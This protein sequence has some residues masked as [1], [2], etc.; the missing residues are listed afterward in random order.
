[1]KHYKILGSFMW[2]NCTFAYLYCR[3][4]AV[5]GTHPLKRQLVTPSPL[6]PAFPL[7]IL[8]P[9]LFQTDG[10]C[11]PLWTP[12]IATLTHG[13]FGFYNFDT[14]ALSFRQSLLLYQHARC[15]HLKY[16]VKPNSLHLRYRHFWWIFPMVWPPVNPHTC[17]TQIRSSQPLLKFITTLSIQAV[18]S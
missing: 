1:M 18:F 4:S 3:L 17:E 12:Q 15:Y 8:N 9:A 5:G 6:A 16:R 11:F 14:S 13:I 2:S 7:H 10:F